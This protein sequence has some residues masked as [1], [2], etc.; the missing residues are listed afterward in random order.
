MTE[1]SVHTEFL[2]AVLESRMRLFNE[3]IYGPFILK[4]APGFQDFLNEKYKPGIDGRPWEIT[5]GQRVSQFDGV[6]IEKDDSL[7]S[8]WVMC[9]APRLESLKP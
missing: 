7:K 8:G 9:E 4:Y 6:S 2:E 5:L 3:K 1:K